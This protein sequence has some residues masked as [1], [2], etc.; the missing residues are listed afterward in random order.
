MSVKQRRICFA[1][2]ALHV[3]FIQATEVLKVNVTGDVILGAVF[4]VHALGA[5]DE[6]GTEI[7]DQIGIQN[8]EA[9]LFSLD[10]V[11]E[12]VLKRSG[13]STILLESVSKLISTLCTFQT[14]VK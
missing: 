14:F 10:K 1:I 11:N 3:C 2:L 8:L 9:L 12:D 13:K 4:P 6:C 7:N 5:G